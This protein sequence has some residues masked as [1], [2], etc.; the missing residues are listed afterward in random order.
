[1]KTKLIIG[2]LALGVFLCSC[3]AE[4][5]QNDDNNLNEIED[6]YNEDTTSETDLDT[7]GEE[8]EPG[9]D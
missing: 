2:A 7:G 3:T 5:L 1:M 6:I 9:E 8:S 4:E